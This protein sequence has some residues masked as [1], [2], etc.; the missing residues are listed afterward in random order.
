MR[1][2]S[3]RF[4][5]NG[6]KLKVISNDCLSLVDHFMA[7]QPAFVSFVSTYRCV[8]LYTR[9]SVV[10]GSVRVPDGFCRRR[11]L[12]GA[13][14]SRPWALFPKTV[15]LCTS[16]LLPYTMF[17]ESVA[18]FSCFF[19]YRLLLNVSVGRKSIVQKATVI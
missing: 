3:W 12:E 6:S 17:L 10:V 15:S 18:M 13:V 4:T 8:F 11:P 14:L 16:S 2:Y 19:T 5:K 1:N 9:Y 7:A